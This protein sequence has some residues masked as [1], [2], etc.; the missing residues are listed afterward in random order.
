MKR[1]GTLL[2]AGSIMLCSTQASASIES[3][4][5]LNQQHLWT[6]LPTT[7]HAEA[8]GASV[9]SVHS[10]TGLSYQLEKVI[11]EHPRYEHYQAYFQGVPVLDSRLVVVRN[12]QGE[13]IQSMG[14][15][16]SG[17]V[18]LVDIASQHNIDLLRI[19]SELYAG[20]Q[21]EIDSTSKAYLLTQGQLLSVT[22]LQVRHNGLK[23]QV[24]L[25]NS[26]G[27]LVRRQSSVSFFT[28]P[29][30][31]DYVAGGG[32][33]G[34]DKLGAICYSPR[35]ESMQ[36]CTA[37]RFDEYTPIGERL[38]FSDKDPGAIFAQFDG[39]PLVVKK[40]QD[41][42]RLENPYL[43][44]FDA[45]NNDTQA[46][47]YACGSNNEN[48]DS[49]AVDDNF[50]TWFSYDPAT[51]AH[52]NAGLVMQY[53]HKQL[54]HL[55]PSQS[56]DCVWSGYCIK[57]L[58]QKVHSNTIHG[59]N[60]AFWD[61]EYVNYGSGDGFYFYSQ[62]TLGIAA[63]E[64][65]H[66]ITSWNA[67]IGPEGV[68]GAINEGFSDLAAIAV[69]DYFQSNAGGTYTQS[70]AFTKQFNEQPGQ[71]NQN[72]KWWFGW[73]AIYEDK[74]ARFYE[75]PSWDGTSIDH[76][77]DFSLA[78]TPHANGGVLRKAFYELVKTKGWSI[79]DAFK[80]FLRANTSGCM[81]SNMSLDEFGYC[82]VAQAP[83]I[84]ISN[85]S[86]IQ[87]KD[88][89]TDV[90]LGVGI[91]ADSSLSTL[92]ANTRVS[93]NEISYDISHLNIDSIEKISAQWG[94]GTS[95]EWHQG[96]N[97]PIYPF[98]QQAHQ[99]PDGTLTRAAITVELTGE[100]TRS[101]YRHFF[102]RPAN[103]SCPP[104]LNTSKVHTNS[105]KVADHATL[106]TTGDYTSLVDSRI[107]LA[108]K[109]SY[110][111]T[112]DKDLSGKKLTILY[113]INKN[114]QFDYTEKLVGNTTISGNTAT[115]A[116]NDNIPQGIGLMRVAISDVK[117]S[118]IDSCGVVDDG[119]VIDL[120]IDADAPN[121][122]VVADF[123]YQLLDDNRVKFTN[124][125][126]VNQVKQPVYRWNFGFN[127]QTSNDENPII[128]FPQDGGTFTVSLT[129]RYQDGSD[130]DSAT[131]TLTLQPVSSCP[132]Q[133]TEPANAD[134]F[135][136]DKLTFNYFGTVL[137]TVTEASG[138]NAT[139]YTLTASS[140][141]SHVGNRT[142]KVVGSTN[143]LPRSTIDSLYGNN[144]IGARFT[145][146]LDKDHDGKF[147]KPE[148]HYAMNDYSYDYYKTDCEYKPDG[149]EYCRVTASRLF[150]LPRVDEDKTFTLRAKF[151]E[152]PQYPL[153]QDACKSFTYGEVEDIQFTITKK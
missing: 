128:Q 56:S 10:N 54:A 88:D 141:F 109:R 64:I 150:R 84:N 11:G 70:E 149:K 96:S 36:A 39:Y 32:I 4:A 80:V 63:H 131:Q 144:Q 134:A 47:S 98:L 58:K 152:N 27:T 67:G 24:I 100:G 145:I 117:Y 40:E 97:Q 120:M 102:S 62:A 132:A 75:L 118:F 115:F 5:L 114:G 71:Y 78:K 87:R 101:A 110:N 121:L 143:L 52:F 92:E 28:S 122:P 14:K 19:A 68:D 33:G 138:F 15:L 81:F 126:T 74:A 9:V 30:L 22:V 113:D 46:V 129:T 119:Q 34:N 103:V 61:G 90:L 26:Q 23:E 59:P 31:N 35:P 25:D 136:I 89:V 57:P 41:I 123:S 45:R 104:Y 91:V 55:Y 2:G 38:M 69:L 51:E 76:A 93:Y 86:A 53:F 50:Y 66:A 17:S 13:I 106:L 1:L 112:F 137:H 108:S 148:G 12:Q 48:F 135:Y 3:H 43:T 18:Q 83:H 140:G 142:I 65:A 151:E 72:R 37:Y 133:I 124:N 21:P 125:S 85:K 82:V 107:P 153:K 29:N 16:L 99:V 127:N 6:K 146:W 116:L 44:T 49:V 77:S 7:V 147:S 95:S 111:L 94:D 42:C 139:G 130:S 60:M 8:P 79:Q 20:R 105:L 73:G